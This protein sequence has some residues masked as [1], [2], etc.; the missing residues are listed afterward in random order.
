VHTRCGGRSLRRRDRRGALGNDAR[1]G[2][3]LSPEGNSPEQLIDTIPAVRGCTAV[4]VLRRWSCNMTTSPA[5][6]RPGAGSRTSQPDAQPG[7]GTIVS[8][9]RHGAFA[10]SPE[11]RA[12]DAPPSAISAT[13]GMCIPPACPARL[14]LLSSTSMPRRRRSCRPQAAAPAAIRSTRS[15]T[16]RCGH[17]RPPLQ[18]AS[19]RQRHAFSRRR[20]PTSGPC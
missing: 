9:W 2:E 1:S 14:A 18:V 19:Q 6:G 4:R 20:K 15:R 13:V 8:L 7:R 16:T 12:D 5:C 10:S 11:Q 17:P 3:G